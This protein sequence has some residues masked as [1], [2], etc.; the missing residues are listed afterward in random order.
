MQYPI[1]KLFTN[2]LDN[3][4]L[5]NL[6]SSKYSC[7]K[8]WFSN[9]VICVKIFHHFFQIFEIVTDYLIL[10]SSDFVGSTY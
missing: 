3:K 5:F 6:P 8:R 2:E 10:S 1:R 4:I 7:H 9:F